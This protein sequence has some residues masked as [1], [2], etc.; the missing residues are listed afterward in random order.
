MTMFLFLLLLMKL[1]DDGAAL[2][3]P[4]SLV[5]PV[6]MNVRALDV[7][8]DALSLTWDY[9]PVEELR[10]FRIFI[11]HED[12]KDVKSISTS[13][14]PPLNISHLEPYS[15]YRIWVKGLYEVEGSGSGSGEDGTQEVKEDLRET[16]KSDSIQVHTDVKAPGIPL[17]SN[18]SCYG[19]NQIWISWSR[20]EKFTKTIDTYLIYYREFVYK[21]DRVTSFQNSLDFFKQLEVE[22]GSGDEESFIIEGLEGKTTYAIRVQAS[23]ESIVFENISFRGDFSQQMLVYLPEEDCEEP[24]VS[25]FG[26][27]EGELSAGMIAGTIFSAIFL[28]LSVV[29]FVLWRQYFKAAYYYL[30]GD[31]PRVVAPVGIPDWEGEPGPDGEKGP[32][33]VDD[34]PSHVAK[35]HADSDIGFSKEYDE[36]QKY[37]CTI[38]NAT[39][40]HSSHPDNK[41]KNRYLNIV[42]YDHSRVQL[43]PISGYKKTSDYINANYIDGFQKFH[44]YIGTQ[45]PLDETFDAYW[46]MIWEQNVYVIV[47]ITN[48]MERGRR[49]C[50][51]YWPKEVNSSE[52]YGHIEVHLAKEEVMANYTIRVMKIKHLKDT[53]E[54]VNTLRKKKWASSDREI[55]QYHYTSWP[56]HGVPAH[57]L[58]VLSFIRRSS[59]SNPPDGGPIIVHCSA[60]VGRTGT[61]IVIDA[62]L[63]QITT[64]YELNIFGFLRHIRGQRN[65]LV[66]TEEQYVFIHDALLEATRSCI[67]EI[68]KDK[69]VNFIDILMKKDIISK[70]NLLQRQFKLITSFEPNDF[71]FMSSR[72]SYN[73]SKCRD[74]NLIPVESFRVALSPKP[75]VEGSDFINATW[76][77][78]NSKLR[79]F[80]ITQ[81]PTAETKEE[82]WSMLW[83]HNAQTVVLLSPIDS[84][85]FPVFWPTRDEEF[86]QECFKVRF[87]EEAIHEGHS[88][89]D[90]VISSRHDDYELEV[91]I[92]HCPDWPSLTRGFAVLKLVQD[93]HLEYQDGPLVVVDKCGGTDAGT[94]CALTTLC[95][96]L[97]TDNAIDVYQVGKLYHNARPG[98]WKTEEDIMHMYKV[99][100]DLISSNIENPLHGDESSSCI[101]TT[102]QAAPAMAIPTSNGNINGSAIPERRHSASDCQSSSCSLSKSGGGSSTITNNNKDTAVNRRHSLPGGTPLLESEDSSSVNCEGNHLHDHHHNILSSSSSSPSSKKDDEDGMIDILQHFDDDDDEKTHLTK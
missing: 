98:L 56:D 57:P 59:R 101:T 86:D 67:T 48:L 60:G 16:E 45:G 47:M 25:P 89:Y 8:G 37:S 29:G 50:D 96:Q 11:E 41:C 3:T 52:V 12:L 30:D 74:S 71:H 85:E 77:H 34:F 28:L 18:A 83:D 36:I 13:E 6:P 2:P 100:A 75:G 7:S 46:R 99:M 53:G 39:H 21:D 88:T 9:P 95:K 17:L 24:P 51:L 20:P 43:A 90:L 69:I 80:V 42:A 55:L 35:L 73:V 68:P 31:P 23:T 58:P 33:M 26:D 70:I 78:G 64:K 27:E 87:I 79:E 61:Y 81:H 91:R 19:T 14:S 10:G 40:E 66:Q 92:I 54:K 1:C 4:V 97:E 94:F 32:V 93:W 15:L 63:Q 62:M 102:T 22:A 65:H 84:D 5:E 38:V 72:K 49:K 76:L 82:F 44:S